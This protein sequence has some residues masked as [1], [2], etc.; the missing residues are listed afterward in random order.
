MRCK[1]VGLSVASQGFWRKLLKDVSIGKNVFKDKD[2]EKIIE[3]LLTEKESGID[4]RHT[5]SRIP[6]LAFLKPD[7]PVNVSQDGEEERAINQAQKSIHICLSKLNEKNKTRVLTN[8][9]RDFSI[10]SVYGKALINA[11]KENRPDEVERLITIIGVNA[12]SWDEEGTPLMWV[13]ENG[14]LNLAKQ[15]VAAGADVN[16][17][18]K[19]GQTALMWAETSPLVA[20]FLIRQGANVHVQ[21]NEESY[22]ALMWCAESASLETLDV[23]LEARALKSYVDGSGNTALMIAAAGEGIETVSEEQHIEVIKRLLEDGANINYKNNDG[24]NAMMLAAKSKRG[25]VIDFLLQNGINYKE[26]DNEGNDALGLVKGKILSE[27][28][29]KIETI[30]GS[31][32]NR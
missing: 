7:V 5:F 19:T 11:A 32:I 12:N 28:K 26:T 21:E 15:L 2:A 1:I 22:T 4:I 6:Y 30:S 29:E 9:S 10:L 3:F 27:L 20:S 13:S 14:H 17:V 16:L 24:Q 8:L 18:D 23:L 31:T 25:K